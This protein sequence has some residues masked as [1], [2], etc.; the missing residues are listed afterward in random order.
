[1]AQLT[2]V[3]LTFYFCGAATILH[4]QS[5]SSARNHGSTDRREQ[6]IVNGVGAARTCLQSFTTS[7]RPAEQ[8][9]CEPLLCFSDDSSRK[10]S[11]AKPNS[12]GLR[13]VN[14]S[15]TQFASAQSESETQTVVSAER[16]PAKSVVVHAA[17]PFEIPAQVTDSER[18]R[19]AQEAV[20]HFYSK[21][22]KKLD[23]TRGDFKPFKHQLI[24][25]SDLVE[26][27]LAP[28]PPRNSEMPYPVSRKPVP[29]TNTVDF[30]E[31]YSVPNTS[32]DSLAHRL[33]EKQNRRPD[34]PIK[35]DH[36]PNN[37]RPVPVA[38]PSTGHARNVNEVTDESELQ[39]PKTNSGTVEAP[40][41]LMAERVQIPVA[42]FEQTRRNHNL[43]LSQ[44]H[45]MDAARSQRGEIPWEAIQ[46]NSGDP[47]KDFDWSLYQT[48]RH[49]MAQQ[50][51]LDIQSLPPLA[52]EP[53]LSQSDPNSLEL[54]E[55]SNEET[56]EAEA[57]AAPKETS[58]SSNDATDA[59]ESASLDK[60][61]R[62]LKSESMIGPLSDPTSLF[63]KLGQDSDSQPD[64]LVVS[65]ETV[66]RNH[67]WQPLNHTWVSP[68]FFH[69]PLYFEQVNLERYG[70]G[71]HSSLQPVLSAVH[72]F[73]SI[74]LAPLK[75]IKQRPYDYVTTLGSY[76]PGNCV[77]K[78]RLH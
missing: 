12:T 57:T 44:Q 46:Q 1:M 30:D 20:E 11:F 4:A 7:K 48:Q 64:L 35:Y 26:E 68:V 71:A 73:G 72:F 51:E 9:L 37:R 13:K 17:T 76:R 10:S 45:E 15:A 50:N 23:P 55:A 19:I 8:H 16:A 54:V 66:V 53:Y 36:S 25:R 39:T 24:M 61:F 32:A 34:A 62:A 41:I 63:A 70:L 67:I 18:R 65:P 47:Q 74:P 58:P 69:N 6:F 22:P 56:E 52:E 40:P 49:L 78:K 14:P 31:L 33:D 38:S 77:P 75:G 29:R 42:Q 60:G 28:A 5:N 21:K 59:Q 3:C 43:Q 27:T 2:K